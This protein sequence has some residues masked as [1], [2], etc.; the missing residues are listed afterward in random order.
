MCQSFKKTFANEIVILSKTAKN[1]IKLK[2][3]F[4]VT[5]LKEEDRIK[6]EVKQILKNDFLEELEKRLSLKKETP[7]QLTPVNEKEE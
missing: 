7:I 2:L 1:S 3:T 6:E 5:P 4:R